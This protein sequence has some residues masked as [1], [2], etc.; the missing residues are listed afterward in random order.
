[1]EKGSSPQLRDVR[2]ARYEASD[3]MRLRELFETVWGENRSIEYDLK[4]WNE[5]LTGVCPA[6]LGLY[7]ERIVGF[8]MV[9]PLLLSDGQ[10][11]VLGEQPIDSM[12]HPDFQ[13]KGM[14]REL[15]C[16]CYEICD[17]EKIS[18]MFGAPNRAAYA[19]NIGPLNWCHVGNIIEAL[20]PLAPAP[21]R[22]MRWIEQDGGWICESKDP[23]LSG[24]SVRRDCP[25][26]LAAHFEALPLLRRRWQMSRSAQWTAYRYRSVPDSEYYS[27]HV[28]GAFGHSGAALCGFR[29]SRQGLK[30]TLVEMAGSDEGSRKVVLNAVAAW[31]RHKGARFLIAKST[32]RTLNEQL[33]WRSFVPFRRTAL[34]SR[35]LS[36]PCY[37]AS[38]FS[39]H[40]WALFGG[41]FDTM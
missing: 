9:W 23:S 4:H 26:D 20:R 12:V 22:N 25:P 41:A 27:I 16:R 28:R 21:Y 24:C 40:A 7:G 29:R 11:Q 18:V 5:T 34:I 6:I 10:S 14:L 19:G 32:D 1:M 15:A 30:A 3:F 31:A 35:T 2:Y 33:L 8:Y 13:G 38:P 39:R 36:W 37:S 17:G